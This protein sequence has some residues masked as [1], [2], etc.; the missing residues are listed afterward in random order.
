MGSSTG[1]GLGM[2]SLGT[3]CPIRQEGTFRVFDETGQVIAYKCGH[4]SSH[5]LVG[6][7]LVVVMGGGTKNPGHR[8]LTLRN[9]ESPHDK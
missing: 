3:L 8:E 2:T 5:L 6:S 9:L 4:Q 7:T 1:C